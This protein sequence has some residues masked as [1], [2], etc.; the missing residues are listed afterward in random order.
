MQTPKAPLSWDE[1]FMLQA[2]MAS[3]RSKDPSTKVGSVL[4]DE[5]NHQISMMPPT[6]TPRS[7]RG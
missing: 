5:N 4:V 3:M 1:Y 6:P 7:R 2:M